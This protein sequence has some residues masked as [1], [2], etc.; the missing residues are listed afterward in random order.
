MTQIHQTGLRL[1]FTTLEGIPVLSS[2]FTE[3]YGRE[4]MTK[5]AMSNADPEGLAP[6]ILSPKT[7]CPSIDLIAVALPFDI[8][9]NASNNHQ[10]PIGRGN[11][12]PQMLAFLGKTVQGVF[13][14]GTAVG[15]A[16]GVVE[17]A[18]LQY[19]FDFRFCNVAAVHSAPCVARVDQTGFMSVDGVVGARAL[20]TAGKKYHSYQSY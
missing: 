12:N 10:S 6:S 13:G 2:R 8:Q 3:W 1:Q 7:A 18:L 9:F 19:F 15:I 4:K 17:F 11:D 16:F 5:N 20:M 14:I